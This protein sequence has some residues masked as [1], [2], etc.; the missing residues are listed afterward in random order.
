[1]PTKLGRVIL[2]GGTSGSGKT[3]VAKELARQHDFSW[4]QVDDLRLAFQWSDVRLPS[5]CA[6]D[7]LYVFT[8]TPR[9]WQ[10]PAS[11]LSDALIDVG[12]AMQDAIAIVAEN[13]VAQGDP[14]IIEGDGILPSIADHPRI[15]PL[16]EKGH[17]SIVFMLPDSQDEIL[18]RVLARGR[19]ASDMSETE[20][21]RLSQMNWLFTKYLREE[22]TRRGLPILSPRPLNSLATR[23]AAQLPID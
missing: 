10:L 12:M 21:E 3:T 15:S 1:M 8:R 18:E 6:T 13:H 14:A 4:I 11:R 19:G 22:A 17:V 2:I 20:L 7:A 5:Q 16:L 9:V 23:I